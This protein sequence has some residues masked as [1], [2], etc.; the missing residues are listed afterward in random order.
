[1]TDKSTDEAEYYLSTEKMIKNA[2]KEIISFYKYL[3]TLST[4]SIVVLIAFINK[5]FENPEWKFLIGVSLIGFVVSIIFGLFVIKMF[6]KLLSKPI[7]DIHIITFPHLRE[8]MEHI[9]IGSFLFGI[10]S[11]TVFGIKNLF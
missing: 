9:C 3:S 1:M 10:V 5:V 8:L 11:L 4:G 7:K 2:V 6:V